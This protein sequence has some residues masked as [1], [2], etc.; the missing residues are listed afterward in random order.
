MFVTALK[1]YPLCG[2]P[3]RT[4]AA[5]RLSVLGDEADPRLGALS[6]VV[7]VAVGSMMSRGM[8]EKRRSAR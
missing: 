6:A 3:G 1:V 7:E 4:L 2:W 5:G 8:D